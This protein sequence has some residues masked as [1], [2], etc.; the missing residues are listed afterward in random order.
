MSPELIAEIKD[1]IAKLTPVADALWDEHLRMKAEVERFSKP[2]EAKT[3]E[4]CDVHN[5][6]NNLKALLPPEVATEEPK[7]TVPF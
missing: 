7:Q 5:K 6:I 1:K 2:S 4:W 3:A